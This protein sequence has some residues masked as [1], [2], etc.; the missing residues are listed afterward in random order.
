V[1]TWARNAA[2]IERRAELVRDIARRCGTGPSA[3]V[4]P[5]IN[6]ANTARDMDRIRIALGERTISY[7]GVSY[8][9]YLGAVYATMFPKRTDRFVLDSLTGTRG[10]DI[11]TSR[12]F[13]LGFQDRF[14]DF[15]A[16]AAARHGSYRLGRTPAEVT[17]T[18]FE[19]AGRLDR[20]PVN[21]I[22]GSTFRIFTFSRLYFDDFF[23]QLAEFWKTLEVPPLPPIPGLE[24]IMAAQLSVVCNDND[25][26]ESVWTYRRNVAVDRIR[27]PMF[28]AA[29]AN[30]WTCAFWPSEPVEP[31]V[32]ITGHGPS[33]ILL[34]Q[35]LRDPATPLAGALLMRGALGH[36]ARMVTVDQGGHGVWLFGRNACGNDAVNRFLVDGQR[37]AR[38]SFCARESETLPA[39]RAGLPAPHPARLI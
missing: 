9:S 29:A 16:W 23:P 5:F 7:F 37:P 2:D 39:S 14:P 22:D 1:P 12:R 3:A 10:L 15:A 24:N 35:N 31:P 19:L 13:G 38:D 11:E 27:F 8:G 21:G 33:N 6:T 34:V 25:W 18:Y 20:T 4:L 17:A 26:P 32:R 28:G 30:V 36:R